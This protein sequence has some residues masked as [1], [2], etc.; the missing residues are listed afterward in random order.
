[1]KMQMRMEMQMEKPEKSGEAMFE[2][3][4]DGVWR[5]TRGYEARRDDRLWKPQNA[6]LG[7]V[8]TRDSVEW[9]EGM[10]L[11][12][13][14]MEHLGYVRVSRADDT[15]RLWDVVFGPDRELDKGELEKLAASK[16]LEVATP[17][18]IAADNETREV[19]KG[20]LIRLMVTGR[21]LAD[22]ETEWAQNPT[23]RSAATL[24]NEAYDEYQEASAAFREGM[25]EEEEG[26]GEAARRA[27]A[28]APTEPRPCASVLD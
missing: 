16:G 25:G 18:E 24:L 3:G 8:V 11:T 1:M 19:D 13:E 7:A 21:K 22:A 12:Y 2:P 6:G 4:E 14:E 20:K 5:Y 28:C 10:E 26:V 23:S 15:W 17:E 9:E 27:L